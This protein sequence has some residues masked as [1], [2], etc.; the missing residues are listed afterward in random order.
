MALASQARSQRMFYNHPVQD[1]QHVRACQ[2]WG[3]K[4][5]QAAERGGPVTAT[6]RHLWVCL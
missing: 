4:L 3:A 1:Y 5:S 6:Q 2:S